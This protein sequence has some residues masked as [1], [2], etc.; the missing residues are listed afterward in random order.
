MSHN[1]KEKTK[2]EYDGEMPTIRIILKS[3]ETKNLSYVTNKIIELAKNN[4]FE[5]SGPR[6]MPNKHLSLTVRKSPCG[7]GTNTYD[8]FE[9][10]IHTRIIE[11]RCPPNS[12]SQITDFKLKPGVDIKIKIWG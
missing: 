8:A 4:G 6:Y 2:G 10:R 11:I 5:T 12:V 3:Q 1:D 9:M 7:E